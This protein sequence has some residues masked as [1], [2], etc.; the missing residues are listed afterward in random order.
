MKKFIYLSA[1]IVVFSSFFSCK[2]EL[3][4]QQKV[5]LEFAEL[6]NRYGGSNYY[7]NL[8]LQSF[9]EEEP[10]FYDSIFD[11]KKL[12][13]ELQQNFT[14]KKDD[15]STLNYSYSNIS[16]PL[17]YPHQVVFKDVVEDTVYVEFS[18]FVPDS[19][20]KFSLTKEDV[21]TKFIK[22]GLNITVLDVRNDAA[23]LVLE[24]T[25]ETNDYSYT[26]GI[27]TNRGDT[28]EEPIGYKNNLF[29]DGNYKKPNKKGRF[30]EFKNDT[31]KVTFDRLS[32]SVA[33]EKGKTIKSDGSIIDFRHYLWY[34]KN[35]M[36]YPEL[37]QSYYNLRDRYKEESKD[38]NHKYNP[39]YVVNLRGMG[40]I[41]KLN[42]FLR[43]NKG[44]KEVLSLKP[45]ANEVLASTVLKEDKYIEKPV[46]KK[47]E[48]LTNSIIKKELK[49]RFVAL[50]QDN[51]Y[52]LYTSLPSN[53]DNLNKIY[54]TDL[55][56]KTEENDSIEVGRTDSY[57]NGFLIGN[58]ESIQSRTFE[59]QD[60]TILYTKVSGTISV[61]TE[62]IEEKVYTLDKLPKTYRYDKRTNSLD[63][64][65]DSSSGQFFLYA[66]T[67]EDL[68]TSIPY[69][70][71]ESDQENHVI[72][73]FKTEPK[74][75]IIRHKPYDWKYS[76]DNYTTEV[77][78]EIEIPS[79][80]LKKE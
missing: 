19:Y 29:S 14:I 7:Y 34:R 76:T 48:L 64:K 28:A 43:S 47:L 65:V 61:S 69:Y 15:N 66:F 35:D 68:E 57:Y 58:P 80:S 36:P 9:Y 27:R 56:V 59:M 71:L 33:D 21:G 60:D 17:Q 73:N 1:I 42:F 5:F 50:N 77:P 16:N 12:E 2:K 4:E 23:T 62:K 13:K 6:E 10:V 51:K 26:Y 75:I 40:K 79:K 49:T 41:D 72:I 22:D 24:N 45:V 39:L 70:V 11:I 52:N 18:V 25:A 53:Y 20:D 55:Y 63:A 44:K 32:I 78:F 74:T 38:P 46:Y 31:L 54:V 37:L 30:T 67:N 8:D 3:T